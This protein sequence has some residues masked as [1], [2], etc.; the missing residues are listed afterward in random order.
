[1]QPS[2]STVNL[3]SSSIFTKCYM[4]FADYVLKLMDDTVEQAGQKPAERNLPPP[5][6]APPSL[7]A[8]YERPPRRAAIDREVTRFMN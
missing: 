4:H 6:P 5:L 2:V 7:S 3:H 1:M 8:G